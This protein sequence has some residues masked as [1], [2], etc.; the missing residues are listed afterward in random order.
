ML[1]FMQC[2]WGF[3]IYYEFIIQLLVLKPVLTIVFC[4]TWLQECTDGYR[5]DSQTGHCKGKV[6]LDAINYFLNFAKSNLFLTLS[7]CQT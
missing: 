2:Y 6:S 7:H 5:W 3:I 1:S 4:S